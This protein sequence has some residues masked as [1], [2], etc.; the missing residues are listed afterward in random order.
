ME[1]YGPWADRQDRGGFP[2]G[3]P[4]DDLG[5]HRAFTWRKGCTARKRFRQDAQCTVQYFDLFFGSPELGR[6]EKFPLAVT[7]GDRKLVGARNIEKIDSSGGIQRIGAHHDHPLSRK[8]IVEFLLVFTEFL[9]VVRLQ[10]EGVSAN[11]QSVAALRQGRAQLLAPTAG[12][13]L[14]VE[15]AA[16][17]IPLVAGKNIDVALSQMMLKRWDPATER[18]PCYFRRYRIGNRPNAVFIGFEPRLEII[19]M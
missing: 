19:D 6:F 11:P 12:D 7:L 14:R 18:L 10:P 13:P 9:P 2:A 5:E 16:F 4:L 15:L 8:R 3:S 17:E 1:L